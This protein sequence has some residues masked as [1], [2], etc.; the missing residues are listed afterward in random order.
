MTVDSVTAL[1][2]AFGF[3]YVP[4]W[5]VAL[6]PGYSAFTMHPVGMSLLFV[7]CALATNQFHI[8]RTQTQEKKF[9]VN[10]KSSGN[11]F[12]R[13]IALD[14]HAALQFVTALLSLVALSSVEYVKFTNNYAHF[15][16]WHGIL[17]LTAS[18]SVVSIFAFASMVH[19]RP[20]IAKPLLAAGGLTPAQFWPAHRI[21]GWVLF[22]LLTVV[23]EFGFFTK[24]M[25][26]SL[27]SLQKRPFSL[28]GTRTGLTLADTF[29][30]SG[31]GL[32]GTI[33]AKVTLQVFS[34]KSKK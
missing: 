5:T 11:S 16:S 27:Q 6:M 23:L 20:D 4:Y 2:I 28:L 33:W 7:F 30:W 15:V 31:V 10:A 22:T 29:L 8:L 1:S 12:T 9:K 17:G 25:E 34:K 13:A 19:N 3:L 24:F 32:V 18:L 26:S 14:R 21:V